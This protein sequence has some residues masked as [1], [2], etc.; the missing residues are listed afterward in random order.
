MCP[1]KVGLLT[2]STPQMSISTRVETTSNS[3][4]H[5][6]LNATFPC[7]GKIRSWIYRRI[8]SRP[9]IF[10]SVWRKE[11]TPDDY[12]RLIGKN[13]LP[14]GSVGYHRMPVAVRDQIAVERGDFIGFHYSGEGYSKFTESGALAVLGAH[15]GSDGPGRPVSRTIRV[16]V[17]Q[18]S[19]PS[20][21]SGVTRRAVDRDAPIRLRYLTLIAG[22]YDENFHVDSPH[23]FHTSDRRWR[24]TLPFL[25]A[26]LDYPLSDGMCSLLLISSLCFQLSDGIY[27]VYCI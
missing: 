18:G 9:K 8:L 13:F 20:G 4:T 6:L 23:T 5:L 1:S 22:Y 16:P 21:P 11:P 25:T 12:F 2:S 10:A 27:N 3:M 17:E 15:G 19:D 14:P 26:L 24:F 7:R